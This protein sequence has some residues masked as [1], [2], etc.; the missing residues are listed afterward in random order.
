MFDVCEST[1]LSGLLT[2]N[3]IQFDF[4]VVVLISF[5][6][7]VSILQWSLL[8]LTGSSRPLLWSWLPNSLQTFYFQNV[9]FCGPP[10]NGTPEGNGNKYK[11][12]TEKL[13]QLKYFCIALP[14][15]F[16]FFRCT[17]TAAQLFALIRHANPV[18]HFAQ[19]QEKVRDEFN[20]CRIQ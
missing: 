7:Q 18:N 15:L 19:S 4:I 12:Y 17:F 14:T 2:R 5:F 16:P 11:C 6:T 13:L 3:K 9:Y 20:I 1:L 8:V 10:I